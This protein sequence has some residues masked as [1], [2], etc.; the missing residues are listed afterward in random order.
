VVSRP[1]LLTA[2]LGAGGVDFRLR[3][4]RLHRVHRGVYAVGH[5]RVSREGRWV[6]AVLACGDGAALSHT[7][8]A[9]LWGLRGT[10][11]ARLHVTVPTNAGVRQ[12]EGIAVHRARALLPGEVTPHEEIRVTS[13]ARTLL[14][15]AGML[16]PG[17]LERAVEQSLVLRLFDLGALEA[18]LDAHPTRAGTAALMAIV[19]RIADEPTPTRSAA[20]ALFLDLCDM[21]AIERPAVNVRLEGLTVDFVWH[22]RRLIVEIDGHR[23]HGTRAAF[24][25]DRVRD[26][27]LTVAGYR[28]V[29]FTYRRLVRAPAAVAAILLRLLDPAYAASSSS[30]RPDSSAAAVSR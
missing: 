27:R 12:R 3:V 6:A 29:R 21:Y 20:E 16:P 7:T 19:A 9:A 28:V 1:Q 15:V 11:A 4:G 13:P 30:S 14:D 22:A 17:P 8:A 18:V 5:P 23:Y 10:S 24:E 26:A 25:R 2:G